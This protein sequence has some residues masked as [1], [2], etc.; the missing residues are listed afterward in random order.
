LLDQETGNRG[1]ETEESQH[2]RRPLCLLSLLF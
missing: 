2:N 1:Q